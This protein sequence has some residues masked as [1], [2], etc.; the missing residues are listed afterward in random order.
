M[1]VRQCIGPHAPAHGERC[2][3]DVAFD[4]AFVKRAVADGLN[5]LAVRGRRHHEV[6]DLRVQQSVQQLAVNEHATAD[7]GADGDVNE[8]IDALSRAPEILAE[9]GGIHIRVKSDRDVVAGLQHVHDIDI[10]PAGLGRCGD[11]A[12]GFAVRI[13]IH[14]AKGADANGL[15]GTM[16]RFRDG[17]PATDLGERFVRRGGGDARDVSQIIRPSADGADEFRSAGLDGSDQRFG[18]LAHQQRGWMFQASLRTA[19]ESRMPRLA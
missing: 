13:H 2:A 12:V 14:R 4:A 15:E 16:L 7:A 5:G 1:I 3:A 10:L 6:T 18:I 8:R 17:K 19:A 11:V 9:H